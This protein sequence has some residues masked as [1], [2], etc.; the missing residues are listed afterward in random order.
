MR[1]DTA[2]VSRVLGSPVRRGGRTEAGGE[3]ETSGFM[4]RDHKDQPV[5]VSVTQTE[6]LRNKVSG[7]HLNRTVGTGSTEK[8]SY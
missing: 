5:L 2:S 8:A 7:S 4:D 1:R 3:A 6:R